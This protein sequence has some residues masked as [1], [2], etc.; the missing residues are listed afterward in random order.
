MN[1]TIRH[2]AIKT[3]PKCDV[4]IIDTHLFK[5]HHNTG[6]MLFCCKNQVW[7]LSTSMLLFPDH[8]YVIQSIHKVVLQLFTPSVHYKIIIHTFVFTDNF[9]MQCIMLLE[10][11]YFLLSLW[12]NTESMTSFIINLLTSVGNI[13]HQHMILMMPDNMIDRYMTKCLKLWTSYNL[14]QSITLQHFAVSWR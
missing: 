9:C 13:E 1:H 8:K 7:E 10:Y 3:A 6:N 11:M 2:R 14:N 12:S 5:G 4:H